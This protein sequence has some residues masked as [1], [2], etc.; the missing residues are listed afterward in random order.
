M[1]HR[2]FAFLA[3]ALVGLS[4]TSRAEESPPPKAEAEPLHYSAEKTR[5]DRRNDRIELYGKAVVRLPGEILRGDTIVLDQK[6]RIVEAKGSATYTSSEAVIYGEEMSF[7]L[8]TRTGTVL[9]GRVSNDRFNLSGD[10]IIK[11]GDQRFKTRWGEFSTC[12]DC[13]NSW[14]VQAEEVDMEFEGYAYLSNVTVWIKGAPT[15]W[16]PYLILPVKKERQTGVLFPRFGVDQNNGFIFTL[17]IFWAISRS[18]DMTL[19]LGEYTNRGRRL[20]LEGR[21]ALAERSFGQA[22]WN[23]VR[24][25]SYQ[26]PNRWGLSVSQNHQFSHVFEQKLRIREASDNNY[27]IFVG[28]VRDQNEPYLTSDL[29]F[30]HASSNV[31]AYLAARRFRNLVNLSPDLSRREIEFDP[32]IVQLYPAASITTNEKP[33]FGT[34]VSAGFTLGV[35]NF[36]RGAEVYDRIPATQASA[37]PVPGIDPIREAVRFSYSPSLYTAFRPWD[38]LSI[39]PSARYF[40]YSYSFRDTTRGLHRGY[41]LLQTDI[42][43]QLERIYTTSDPNR[44]K[45]KHLIRPMLT[46]SLIP[47]V[48][49][50]R[51]HPFLQQISYAR[52]QG[53]Q[54]YYF[55]NNDIVPR[56]ATPS[57]LN[58]FVPLGHSV[59]YGAST[60]WIRR[61]GREDAEDPYYLRQVE[62]NA[63]QTF[64][65]REYQNNNSNPK[66]LSRLFTE[67]M[68]NFETFLSNT[69]YFYYPYVANPRHQVSTSLTYI[70]ERGMH[71]RFLSFDRSIDIGYVW[72][73]VVPNNV[74]VVYSQ[75]NFSINDYILPSISGQYDLISREFLTAGAGL[76]FQ[77]PSRCWRLSVTTAYSRQTKTTQ[78]APDLAINLTG[79][80]FW[81][82]TGTAPAA[83]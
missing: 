59:S 51:S 53:W 9:R 65:I 14:S 22:N 76:A 43:T 45:V 77:S 21:Y 3:C 6:N 27:P 18:V 28:D 71:Q 42:T 61:I 72:N 80:G 37:T 10:R 17:P 32:K 44:P 60:Q 39:T 70:I 19:G 15:V 50:D 24:D 13:P 57:N 48:R 68:L 82:V 35:M 79:D 40:G 49:E 66:P 69:S 41:L 25:K 75:L 56:D 54:G 46:Y 12:R 26:K 52:S 67:V 30:S 29:I 33:L 34:P 8:D 20:E 36:T 7:N 63:G 23:Y 62:V 58:Y 11:L 47:Y 5:W 78:W 74:H 55:D 1:N 31:S 2:G 64:N 38:L 83:R 16:V 73:R 81:G 4:L